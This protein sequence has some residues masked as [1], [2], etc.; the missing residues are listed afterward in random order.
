[1]PAGI[2]AEEEPPKVSFVPV[3]SIRP[4]RARLIPTLPAPIVKGTK[5]GTATLTLPDGKVV[6]YPLEAAVDVPRMGVVGRLTAL[7]HHYLFGWLS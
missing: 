2:V 5:L 7:I 3:P 6:E 1:L 4:R